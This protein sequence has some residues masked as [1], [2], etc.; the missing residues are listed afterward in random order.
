LPVGG[1]CFD[2]SFSNEGNLL[3]QGSIF[4][5]VT[6]DQGIEV[7]EDIGTFKVTNNKLRVQFGTHEDRQGFVWGVT[8][9]LKNQ[10]NRVS[11]PDDGVEHVSNIYSFLLGGY[12]GQNG[13]AREGFLSKTG[14]RARAW[15]G[16]G[17][18]TATL[19]LD[20]ASYREPDVFA[21]EYGGALDLVFMH[22]RTAKGNPRVKAGVQAELSRQVSKATGNYDQAVAGLGGQ[23][24][25]ATLK[26]V[27]LHGYGNVTHNNI[28]DGNGV[29]THSNGGL[30]GIKA[31]F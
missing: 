27:E 3:K 17:A 28:N 14:A 9:D 4:R 10:R 20:G 30:V 26:G 22:G 8:G 15:F 7:R 12:A 23:A 21:S 5:T 18:R 2:F 1:Y 6:N 24:Y 11:Y 25:I 19:K 13:F 16:P 31:H 29:K